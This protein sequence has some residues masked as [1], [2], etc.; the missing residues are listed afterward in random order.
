MKFDAST[1]SFLLALVGSTSGW[2]AWWI[3][4]RQQIIQ[5]A[6][7]DAEKALNEKRDFN[8]LVNNQLDISKNIAFGFDQLEHQLDDIDNELREL[9]AYLIGNQ[10]HS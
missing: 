2:V 10:K 6:V 5:K 4:K 3:N 8:H 7:K 9:K 1:F